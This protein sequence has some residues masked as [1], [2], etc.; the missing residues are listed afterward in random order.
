M[1]QLGKKDIFAPHGAIIIIPKSIIQTLY[2][3][4]DEK[5]FLFA[6]EDLLGYKD[7]K[8][9]IRVEYNPNIKIRHKE[10]GSVAEISDRI[11]SHIRDSYFI[12]TIIILRIV[13][14]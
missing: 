10:D 3:I 7:A 5:M 9:K 6:E 13:I 2:P 8:N 14:Q 12:Y 1:R 4:F 11:Y